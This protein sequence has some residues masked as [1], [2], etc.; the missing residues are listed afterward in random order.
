MTKL[1]AAQALAN[2]Q[3]VLTVGDKPSR[4]RRVLSMG[5]ATAVLISASLLA[6]APA[7]AA[8]WRNALQSDPTSA[9]EYGR[10][11]ALR[12]TDG[13]LAE[14]VMVRPVEMKNTNRVTLGGA[15]GAAA[16]A[17]AAGSID[18]GDTRKVARILLGG[19]GAVGGHKVQQRFSTRDG[20]QITVMERDSRGRTKLTNVVQDADQVIQ[21]GDVVMLEGSGSRIRVVPLDPAF[22]AR[23]RGEQVSQ[24]EV[25]FGSRADRNQGY[26]DSA[27]SRRRGYGR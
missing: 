7:E 25:Q 24:D 23:L 14:V 8:N 19:L 18:D 5:A 27:P 22:Q 9:R 2:P 16:G 10:N 17:A 4:F 13:R 3:A 20:V 6:P 15:V 12:T 11:E 21:P 1:S 26:D